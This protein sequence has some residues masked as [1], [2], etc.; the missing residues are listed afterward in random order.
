MRFAPDHRTFELM[1]A[2]VSSL[3]SH[4]VLRH[5]VFPDTHDI[6]IETTGVEPV[7]DDADMDG[8]GALNDAQ[9]SAIRGVVCYRRHAAFVLYGPAGT[10]KTSTVAAMVKH[11]IATFAAV[12]PAV[13]PPAAVPFDHH[14]RYPLGGS[15]ATGRGAGVA[16]GSAG[17]G[18][19]GVARVLVCAPLNAAC[20]VVAERI[21]DVL[22]DAPVPL[23]RL[24]SESSDPRSLSARLTD[25]SNLQYGSTDPT[26]RRVLE[27]ARFVMPT[28]DTLKSAHVRCFCSGTVVH[29]RS[30]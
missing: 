4:R 6:R 14:H 15:G 13:V 9:C 18:R 22:R 25:F 10:G 1:R 23:L 26:T 27:V 11:A 5:I 3:H 8:G 30:L 7:F 17:G 29:W 24:L 12:N 21:I 19:G 20:D 2:A 28:A 16:R